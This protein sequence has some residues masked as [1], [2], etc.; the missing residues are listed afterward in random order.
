MYR[1]LSDRMK[2]FYEERARSF[3]P[4]RVP[5]IIRI[6]GRAFHTFCRGMQKPFD[7]VL[8]SSMYATAQYLVSNIM[9]A[10]L[11]YIQS[12]EISILVTDFE[13]VN[14]SAWFDYETLK[15]VSVSAS[16]ATLEF[17]RSFRKMDADKL[18]QAKYDNAT[19]DSRAFSLPQE[20][21]VNY[22]IWRELDAIRNSI[23]MIGRTEFSHSELV[24]KNTGDI[25]NMLERRGI[26]YDNFS[27]ECKRGA[28]IRKEYMT[29]ENDMGEKYVRGK[30]ILDTEIPL[31]TE[32]REY[33][34]Q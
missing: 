18:Y 32:D 21:V 29:L 7:E 33:V 9:G 8:R 13:G 6:D 27:T 34:W 2:K 24:N 23:Q 26:V 16:M 28:C 4:R 22:F 20:E 12:D 31:F 1:K 10:R 25:V 14:T 19:F 5:V 15:M 3:L 11:A 17:N 30:W